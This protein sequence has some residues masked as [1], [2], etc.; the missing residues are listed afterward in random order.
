MRRNRIVTLLLAAVLA[1]SATACTASD[2]KSSG[3]SGGEGFPITVEHTYGTT[4]IESKPERVATVAWANHEVPL[5]LGV[6]PVGMSKATWG[7]DNGNG[8]LPWV[9]D[10]LDEL[11][12]EKPALFDET[13]GIDFEA[14]ANTEPDVI[15]AGYSGVTK[16]EY[17]KL[18]Q[19]APTVAYPKVPWGTSWQ[20]MVKID[21][22]AM[23]METQ[24]DELIDR[25]NDRVGASL[26]RHPELKSTK[27]LFVFLD[28]TDTSKIGYYTANDTRAGF[29]REIGLPLPAQ[30][31]KATDESEE[32]YVEVSAEKADLFKD[33]GLFVTY[34]T[35]ATKAQLQADPLLNK[36][37]AVKE[38]RIA[39]LPDGTPLAS[40]ANPSPLSIPWGIDRYFDTLATG[41]KT[42]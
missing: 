17:D 37:P 1:A 27:P 30:V 39:I 28:P 19:I 11:G 4:T 40:M 25:L 35:E 5:A 24:G 15:L 10:K 12:G 13:D 38:G 36:I 41:L 7:D 9:E 32:F 26:N 6:T 16:Q 21:S 20:D 31:A 18:S 14:V 33:V 3:E 22:K 29:L 8:I 34:G 42:S 23:G 2:E